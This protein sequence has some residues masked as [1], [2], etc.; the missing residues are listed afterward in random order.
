MKSQ[1][2]KKKLNHLYSSSIDIKKD[3]EVFFNNL[4]LKQDYE[5]SN[6]RINYLKSPKFMKKNLEA[7]TQSN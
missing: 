1:N 5:N 4:S 2:I 3:F 6:I 7:I